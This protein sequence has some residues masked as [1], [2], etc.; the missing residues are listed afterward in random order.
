MKTVRIFQPYGAHLRFEGAEDVG[1]SPT[2]LIRFRFKP[3]DENG[4]PKPDMEATAI[5]NLSTISPCLN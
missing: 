1:I 4:V 2:G 5:F 3:K